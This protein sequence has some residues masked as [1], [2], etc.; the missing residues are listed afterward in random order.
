MGD[1]EDEFRESRRG[2]L[3]AGGPQ[4]GRR[5]RRRPPPPAPARGDEA[6]APGKTQDG[7]EGGGGAPSG[8]SG[9]PPASLL[10]AP[11]GAGDAAA[12]EGGRGSRHCQEQAQGSAQVTLEPLAL[13]GASARKEEEEKDHA[14]RPPACEEEE[15]ALRGDQSWGCQ[16]AVP[17]ELQPGSL[18]EAGW[19]FC[20]I[21]QKDLSAMN[22]VRREQHVNRCLDDLEGPLPAPPAARGPVVPECPICGKGF[23]SLRSRGG[24][25][26]RCA[27]RM[28]VPPTLLL[29]AV[30][31]QQ[32]ETL[33][34]GLPAAQSGSKRKGASSTQ[35][36]PKKRKVA[37]EVDGATEDLLVAMAM[38]RSL[39]EEEEGKAK[40]LAGSRQDG[41]LKSRKPRKAEKKSRAKLGLPLPPLPL[42][43]PQD[44]QE[45]RRRIEARVAQ[46]LS[47]AEE[48]EFPSTP[49][50]PPSRLMDAELPQ[51]AGGSLWEASSLARLC[52][53]GSF[54]A[55]DFA[56][57][58]SL[59]MPKEGAVLGVALPSLGPARAPER[60]QGLAGAVL[61]QGSAPGDSRERLPCRPG[62]AEALEDLV[63]LAGEGLTLTQWQMEGPGQGWLP[64]DA[65]QSSFLQPLEKQLPQRICPQTLPLGSL[66]DAFR[67]MV[68]NP[69]L[70][71]I[72][73]QV[74]TGEVL[75]A[76]L[77]VLYARCPQLMEM[78]GCEGFLVAEEGGAGTR[79]VLLSDVSKEALG[80]FL[81]YLYTADVSVPRH[82]LS[83]VAALAR[84]FGATELAG[85]CRSCQPGPGVPGAEDEAGEDR[86]GTFEELLRSMWLEEE[87]EAVL[88]GGQL[89]EA[90]SEEVGEQELEQIYEFAATQRKAA[91]DRLV[92][93]KG[94]ANPRKEPAES[95]AAMAEW[96]GS[97]CPEQSQLPG[98]AADAAARGT[99][100]PLR[101]ATG[102][103][104][105]MEEEENSEQ[106]EHSAVLF[107][108]TQGDCS[109][110]SQ[111]S[112]CAKEQKG[113]AASQGPAS[114]GFPSLLWG[115]PRDLLPLG[116]SSP[117][118]SAASPTSPLAVLS[119]VLPG[120]SPLGLSSPPPHGELE[121]P[122]RNKS[123]G[124]CG[125]LES[126]PIVL[127][128]SDEEAE[129]A[130]AGVLLAG[131][132]L[133]GPCTGALQSSQGGAGVSS[134]QRPSLSPAQVGPGELWD[135]GGGSPLL[136]RL[137][138]NGEDS[139]EEAS[140]WRV[141]DTP[142]LGGYT[143]A[144]GTE[145]QGS[146]GAGESL[147]THSSTPRLPL[148]GPPSAQEKPSS[149]PVVIVG[150]SEEELDSAAPLPQ[151]GTLVP[152]EDSLCPSEGEGDSLLCLTPNAPAPLGTPPPAV[153]VK[154]PP[155][156][157]PMAGGAAAPHLGERGASTEDSDSSEVFPL[158]QRTPDLAFEAGSETP[159]A[160]PPTP[161]PSYSIMETPKLKKELRRFGVR[162][163][164]KRK[165]I[166][167][168]KEIFQYTHQGARAN[169][170]EKAAV[171]SQ[172]TLPHSPAQPVPRKPRLAVASSPVGKRLPGS[173]EPHQGARGSQMV[174]GFRDER[175]GQVS[176]PHTSGRLQGTASLPTG[177]PP[178]GSTKDSAPTASQE[179]TA[180]SGTG[181]D[182]SVVSQSSSSMEF[183]SLV[184]EEEE[185]H[186]PASQA[187][188][189]EA[190]KLE[191][192]RRHLVSKPALC[193]QILLY[194]PIE[195]AGL[196][197]E[198]KESGIR[199]AMGKLMDFL[200]AH[201]ITFTTAEARREKQRHSKKRRRRF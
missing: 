110:L 70:S 151:S 82:V 146:K 14:R 155:A 24:H 80:V 5:L 32:Q 13:P 189:R 3:K 77:F 126:S 147:P 177:F 129:R 148:L 2:R 117:K 61:L 132:A 157:S 83:E 111:Q 109:G 55:T 37:A 174:C 45:T 50:L 101:A 35:R 182:V 71:D 107:P 66:A 87:E 95:R 188:V 159:S 63:E 138:S 27:A 127:L 20:Q 21:C 184:E 60:E 25:L 158:T 176:D 74:D 145:E 195:L 18:E 65:Q 128:D 193:R 17:E 10:G 149:S 123:P 179:S 28:E 79:R 62:D 196:Q 48:E 36:L 29:Q 106:H 1:S 173:A 93:R 164:P 153:G 4:G 73:F 136:L 67:G 96:T 31:Q 23:S 90:D 40:Q 12:E 143:L 190:H 125:T 162:A 89:E 103:V 180:S 191:A 144:P 38:S 186:V 85:M 166:L 64:G 75:Y 47:E 81:S 94:A 142:L 49:L 175:L 88:Q 156:R 115:P 7:G 137:A 100:P 76:H 98:A 201:C 9:L 185:E 6:E 150:D 54:R 183:G 200:D 44:P 102:S 119:L 152:G 113:N 99:G 78:V 43:L 46:L 194:Q 122:A 154:S 19:V 169:P 171:A 116:S 33:L 39:L 84:R 161:M 41:A 26:K 197:A 52:P 121:R 105:Q 42:L 108:A 112:H 51:G 178:G 16:G 187:A 92:F 170:Q 8:A 86:A 139:W 120:L 59:Q 15:E 22:S 199:I 181:S 124:G 34:L 140:S 97:L 167:K 56:R 72:Q 104:P 30:R 68:N 165:M 135:A 160:A 131:A 53:P 118:Q 168:L 91:H 163:L 11:P 114:Q 57:S 192:L 133:S 198:L 58:V 69:H 172:R 130:E 134:G 141:P